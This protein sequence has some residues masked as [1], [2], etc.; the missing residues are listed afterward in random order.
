MTKIT[1]FILLLVALFGNSPITGGSIDK[2][3]L[4]IT[5]SLVKS[6]MPG[7]LL[8]QIQLQNLSMEDKTLVGKIVLKNSAE[9]GRENAQKECIIYLEAQSGSKIRD[10]HPCKGTG[11]RTWEF[12]IIKIY[13]FLLPQEN[14]EKPGQ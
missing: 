13:P 8:F 3:G 10:I 12:H 6:D 1:T 5:I 7:Y 2:D 11:Y 4:Q 9:P 14:S